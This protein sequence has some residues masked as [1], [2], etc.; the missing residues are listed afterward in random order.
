MNDLRDHM[1]PSMWRSS[2]SGSIV[3]VVIVVLV[4]II[5]GVLVIVVVIERALVQF[6]KILIITYPGYI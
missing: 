5:V 2:S 1:H 4:V 6:F 3:T